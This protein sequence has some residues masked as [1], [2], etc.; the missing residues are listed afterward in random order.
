MAPRIGWGRKHVPM[1]ASRAGDALLV[2]PRDALD[3][4]S[5]AFAAGL[6]PDEGN[7]LVVLD[8]PAD[9]GRAA[10]RQV[11]SLL[12][13]LE[14]PLRMVPGRPPDEDTR[15]VGQWFADRLG[16]TV[17]LPDGTL[18]VARGGALYVAA[19]E[20][21]GWLRFSPDASP[22]RVSQ[23]Y[24]APVWEPLVPERPWRVSER[25][26]VEPL[27][28]GM[29]VRVTADAPDLAAHRQRLVAAVQPRRD[30]LPVA[31]GS[32]GGEPV[33][34][35]DVA[36][37]W[38]SVRIAARPLVRFFQYGP[39][40]A[41][42][43][44]PL[45][46]S[47]ADLLD[48][49]VDC[50]NGLPSGTWHRTET[51]VLDGDGKETWHAFAQE[52][53][54]HPRTAPGAP[55]PA[56]KVLAHRR[57]PT[58][59]DEVAPGTYALESGAVLEVVQSG[60]WVRP[61]AVPE[62]AEAVRALPPDPHRASLLHSVVPP[63]SERR[64]RELAHRVLLDLD[65]ETRALSLVLPA[66]GPAAP[67]D[68][69][70]P[71]GTVPG[72]PPSVPD[73]DTEARRPA[74]P[75][76]VPAGTV[77]SSSPRTVSA[78]A[79]GLLPP[80]PVPDGL[81]E[82]TAEAA[83]RFAA[84]VPPA[85]EDPP[86]RTGP[87]GTEGPPAPAAGVTP[88]A[89]LGPGTTGREAASASLPAGEAG[90]GAAGPEGAGPS[91][92]RPDEPAGPPGAPSAAGP[93]P[94]L[95]TGDDALLNGLV[96]PAGEEE[97]TGA[98]AVPGAPVERSSSLPVPSPAPSGVRVQPVPP[99]GTRTVAETDELD[100]ARA[101]LR[102]SFGADYDTAAG[103]VLRTLSEVPGLRGPSGDGE[104]AVA[105]LTAA[106]LYLTGTMPELDR[107]LRA[108]TPGTRPGTARC[109]VAGLRR[110]PSYRGAA[111]MRTDLGDAEFAW[112]RGRTTVVDWSLTTALIRVDPS[113]QGNTDLLFW[114][115]TARRTALLD[116]AF[117]TRV[118]FLPETRFTVLAVREDGGRRS[119]WLREAA[120]GEAA[121]EG[122]GTGG[123]Q[124][125]DQAALVGL[126]QAVEKWAAD[127]GR[128]SGRPAASLP[129][130][131]TAPGLVTAG[132][133]GS[134]T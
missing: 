126:E 16:R 83:G 18:R 14:G 91:T 118:V 69:R 43:P 59:G 4:R 51:H 127:T 124:A 92:E 107:E 10:W 116:R 7:A 128:P 95:L 30:L 77:A 19:E 55:A 81:P 90:P 41:A 119:V 71:G 61:A 33:P 134:G 109:V 70:S 120:A 99:S 62:G 37:Y 88:A 75:P 6:P 87:A 115:A 96:D 23:R 67:E 112:F 2:H 131:P 8:L 63:D 65:A 110:L 100:P 15:T 11:A 123:L 56:P 40:D 129:Y 73:P 133:D 17:L 113:Q 22:V 57:P 132:G 85:P 68:D 121:A 97:R 49:P 28:A 114:A 60:L 74:G 34:L 1:A 89:R 27:P 130:R 76:P 98:P 79:G 58:D 66:P 93:V 54:F 78:A 122:G 105:D 42:R 102:T 24:P 47:L 9:S 84:A 21:S 64:L 29:W 50:F 3:D 32:P 94:V 82:P 13:E 106:R 52:V 12:E 53:R 26:V 111:I 101:E 86:D 125:A 117:P 35:R 104:R 80:R 72:L 20:G 108:G 36:R 44:E 25:T 38:D 103:S 48:R 45:G 46:Q 31:V 5:R 39:V